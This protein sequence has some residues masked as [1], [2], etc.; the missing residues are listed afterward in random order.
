MNNTP[1]EVT[2]TYTRGLRF[3]A[4]KEQVLDA[5]QRNGAPRDVVEIIDSR[6]HAKFASPADIMVILRQ[7]QGSRVAPQAGW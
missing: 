4:S 3:P 6:P 5:L 2:R 7:E 1:L